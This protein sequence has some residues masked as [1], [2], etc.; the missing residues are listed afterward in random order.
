[1][2]GWTHSIVAGRAR[3]LVL[4]ALLLTT[5][6]ALAHDYYIDAQN[7]DNRNDG[8]ANAP[9]K[10][11]SFALTGPHAPLP[12]NSTLHLYG[13][14]GVAYGVTNH[15]PLPWVLY[16]NISIVAD[17]SAGSGTDW[18]VEAGGSGQDV[19]RLSADDD[20]QGCRIQGIED[21]DHRYDLI[22]RNGGRGIVSQPVGKTHAP[23]IQYC[24]IKNM[25]NEAIRIDGHYAGIGHLI[26]NNILRSSGAAQI[27][28]EVSNCFST[29]VIEGNELV[30]GK[31]DGIYIT[32]TLARG[33]LGVRRNTISSSLARYE[34]AVLFNAFHGR[35]EFVDNT[36]SYSGRGCEGLGILE[37][38]QWD[39]LSEI[40]GNLLVNVYRSALHV[41]TTHGV[42]FTNNTCT[43]TTAHHEGIWLR[44]SHDAILSGNLC[45]GSSNNGI[46]L[47]N[48]DRALIEN[49]T[50][51]GSNGSGIHLDHGSTEAIVRNNSLCTNREWGINSSSPTTEVVNN[52]LTS[53]TLGG[54]RIGSSS[55]LV[56][57]NKILANAGPGIL[58]TIGAN[59]SC[60][61]NLVAKNSGDGIQITSSIVYAP[62]RIYNNTVANNGGH[63]IRTKLVPDTPLYVANCIFSGNGD[64]DMAGLAYSQ[65][66]NCC[67]GTGISPGYGNLRADPLFV[68]AGNGDYHLSSASPCIEAG[69][70]TMVEHAT[71]L[72]GVPRILD[73][74]WNG[75]MTVDIGCY[76]YT[77]VSSSLSGNH[78]QG[79]DLKLTVKGPANAPFSVYAA[80]DTGSYPLAEGP[81]LL[82]PR[83]GTVVLNVARLYSETPVAGGST[84]ST[85]TAT[86]TLPLP[87][88]SA[89]RYV[90]LQTAVD[91]PDGSGHGQCTEAET[92][93]IQP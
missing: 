72:D 31:S 29:A 41:S 24:T 62:P 11:V 75:S 66:M 50:V 9:W 86:L 19:I 93:I 43:G 56:L 37:C 51:H 34:T 80:A 16:N 90:A 49:N 4:G 67:A 30:S 47:F 13:T 12:A 23:T 15:D 8:S 79:G 38:D 81:G 61:H 71:D 59:S 10:T 20:F 26:R 82:H 6:A 1:M 65:Y 60:I 14:D 54:L 64:L 74:A 88:G 40:D 2:H 48:S 70:N 69:S 36:L 35:V 17:S 52:T 83:Y 91:A 78:Q 32:G 53:N 18:I 84:D 21:P 44:K 58:I 45:S 25:R 57:N 87:P 73:G 55:A 68:D 27:R 3:A 46:Y 7:G 28:F 77:E 63:G 89:G 39:P 92:F 76:E 33:S 42:I 22:L 5:A 85:G